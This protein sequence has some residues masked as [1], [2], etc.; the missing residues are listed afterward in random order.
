MMLFK[1]MTV[2]LLSVIL[3]RLLIAYPFALLL[4]VS[5]R[6]SLHTGAIPRSGGLAIVV[7]WLSGIAL[8]WPLL[9]SL[10]TLPLLMAGGLLAAV[11]LRDDMVPVSA[12]SR[13]CVHVMVAVIVVFVAGLSL[14]V[15]ALLPMP[16]FVM[17]VLSVLGVVWMIN[18]Y[19]FM[20]GMDGFAAAMT[21][22][23][24]GSLALVGYLA[25]D[26][27]YVNACLVVVAAVA[28]F[29]IWNIPP[30]RIF[31]GDV[32]STVLGLLVV[33]LAL[34]GIG[35]GLFPFWAPALAFSPFWIDATYTLCK[36]IYRREPFWEAHRSHFYQR[37]VLVNGSHARILAAEVLLMLGCAASAALPALPELGY[38]GLIP[39][40]WLGFYS[41]LIVV[42][43]MQLTSKK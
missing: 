21:I 12:L 42:L 25:G 26:F 17:Q 37:L 34:V 2:F 11:S 19:N 10:Y 16:V 24:L 35:R 40:I 29:A 31:M 15:L 28:G 43:E 22:I 30:A 27:Q 6:R 13:L 7:A 39:L 33:V 20:D 4:D 8:S 32:G 1:L 5:G 3:V 41:V 14:P 36:R 38:N 9:Q 23:G 18:L